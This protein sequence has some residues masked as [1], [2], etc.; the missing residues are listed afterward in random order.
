MGIPRG[1]CSSRA[2]NSWPGRWLKAVDCSA[3]TVLAVVSSARRASV[4]S[5]AVV[6]SDPGVD[7]ITALE[8]S[9][10]G[11]KLTPLGGADEPRESGYLVYAPATRTLY[12]VDG[13][14]THRARPPDVPLGEAVLA[15][16]VLVQ[17]DDAR[18]R[19]QGIRQPGDETQQDVPADGCPEG[20]WRPGPPRAGSARPRSGHP[21]QGIGRLAVRQCPQARHLARLTWGFPAGRTGNVTPRR[22]LPTLVGGVSGTTA[23]H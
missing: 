19:D 21:G 6:R 16:G 14:A 17:A 23:S 15:L 5:R 10:D 1:S 13:G 8:V 3:E 20:V 12:A 2:R 22:L 4:S 9:R 7:G 11:R 18:R